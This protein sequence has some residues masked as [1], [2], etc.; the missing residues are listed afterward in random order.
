MAYFFPLQLREEFA[1]G[2]PVYLRA[3]LTPVNGVNEVTR[4]VML[5]IVHIGSKLIEEI[6]GHHSKV[7]KVSVRSWA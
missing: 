5:R 2:M 6:I 1:E 7:D 4:K 3:I